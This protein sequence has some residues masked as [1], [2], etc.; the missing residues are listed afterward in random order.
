VDGTDFLA[1]QR[2]FGTSS[3]ASLIDGDSDGDM[4]VDSVDFNN[5]ESQFGTMTGGAITAGA[6]AA[7]GIGSGVDYAA[8][9]VGGTPEPSS[10]V[11]AGMAG[12]GG[13]MATG[14]RR[15]NRREAQKK[16]VVSF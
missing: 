6:V 9:S 2:G 4:D 16:S 8:A 7:S 1:W 13:L 12:L 14:R 10:L 5:W 3:G 11:L 15:K